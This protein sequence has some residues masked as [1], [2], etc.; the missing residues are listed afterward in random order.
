MGSTEHRVALVTGGAQGIG[1][2]IALSLAG[3]GC[4]VAIVDL[5]PDGVASAV[6]E[7]A[8][9]GRR[10]FGLTGD[11]SSLAFAQEAIAKTVELAG[12]V[13]VL[14]N[15]AGITRDGL[16]LRMKPEDWDAVLR[17]NLTGSFNFCKAAVPALIKQR[18]GRIVN[19]SSVVGAMGNAGQVNYAA[20]KAGLIGLTKSLAREVA[21]RGVTVNAVAPGFIDTAMTQA[22]P[23]KAR[24]T[25]IAQIP[26][27]R[28]G[29]AGDVAAAVGYLVSE[30]AGYVTGQVLHVNGGLYT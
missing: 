20:S 9:T 7:V 11:V 13:H 25:L 4:D 14:V 15:N 27:G 16:I 18:W 2:A 22:M 3:A 24:E 23:A 28:L 12:A 8:A 26:A 30:G 5:N 29:Q 21:S 17:V 1:R 19:I 6:A 10:A